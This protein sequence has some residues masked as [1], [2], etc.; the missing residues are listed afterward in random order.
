MNTDTLQAELD[1]ALLLLESLERDGYTYTRGY[2]RCIA[3]VR[4]LRR[5]IYR[6]EVLQG[7][8]A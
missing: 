5:L 7:V 4:V 3:R 6:L 1:S 2:R 8:S